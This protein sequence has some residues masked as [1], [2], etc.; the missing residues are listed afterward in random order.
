VTSIPY[1]RVRHRKFS[2]G[3]EQVSLRARDSK[4]PF[5]LVS[6]DMCGRLKRSIPRHRALDMCSTTRN[7]AHQAK[8]IAT[9]PHALLNPVF[10]ALSVQH[11][12]ACSFQHCT[13]PQLKA[14]LENPQTKCAFST[15]RNKWFKECLH[16][17]NFFLFVCLFVC[18]NKTRKTILQ[19]I[20]LSRSFWDD[21]G[22]FE[23]K[24]VS[25]FFSCEH[26]VRNGL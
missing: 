13:R 22:V 5:L 25:S 1:T 8:I 14:N 23:H 21:L 26:D 20:V 4:L 17:A 18:W 15:G 9:K 7:F 12:T 16:P 10:S 19:K 11:P 3:L 6:R 24:L 2:P